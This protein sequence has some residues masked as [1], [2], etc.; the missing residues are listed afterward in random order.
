M[1][2]PYSSS[3]NLILKWSVGFS[4]NILL[5]E[6]SQRFQ[7][8]F[9]D[10]IIEIIRNL[11]N[12]NNKRVTIQAVLALKNFLVPF[13]ENNLLIESPN[14][15]S[16]YQSQILNTLKSIY[17]ISLSTKDY[18]LLLQVIKSVSKIA[19]TLQNLFEPFLTV[20]LPD[21][22]DLI[23]NQS[24]QNPK[25]KAESIKC[26]GFIISAVSESSEIYKKDANNAMSI[27]TSLRNT[28]DQDDICNI[29]IL[30]VIPYFADILKEDFKEYLDIYLPEILDKVQ[31]KVDM[32]IT[33]CEEE[34]LPPGIK[35][36]KIDTKDG[37]K[38][39]AIN[40]WTLQL[41]IKAVQILHDV[42][43]STLYRFEPYIKSTIDL[44]IPL[45]I[46][47]YNS[48]IRKTSVKAVT[49]M[50]KNSFEKEKL[51]KKILPVYI[52][53]LSKQ[54]M[55]PLD[56]KIILKGMLFTFHYYEELSKIGLDTGKEIAV[57]LSNHA[58]SLIS[59][60]TKRDQDFQNISNHDL[61]KDKITQIESEEIIDNKILRLV[62]EVIGKL[63]KAFKKDL[64][65]I[66]LIHFKD[67]YAQY[68]Y[69]E[70]AEKL[71]IL[72]AI[73]IF[74]DYVEF[75]EDLMWEL[76]KSRIVEEMIK[77]SDNKNSQIKQSALYGLG[78][79]AKV[80]DQN[81]FLIYK[82]K[83]IEKIRLALTDPN[84]RTI[85]HDIST[86]SAIGALGKIAIFHDNAY[87]EE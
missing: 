2:F 86:D 14:L 43:A 16:N 11:L 9:Q 40:N 21:F 75:C 49:L 46:Y 31:V 77:Y 61:Y 74:V 19:E 34:D 32:N 44:L 76:E 69:K 82:E 57:L 85:K 68:F 79:C 55:L 71:E 70:N 73:C 27:L 63:L 47:P 17:D 60:K 36:V 54:S 15:L 25:I 30:Q 48:D 12:S 1:I 29:A 51:I 6:F 66:F 59:R 18:E 87:I 65:S 5:K 4:I 72:S 64:Q 45:F 50:I 8:I 78:V 84:P 56:V 26:I 23:Q 53:T 35:I 3:E 37:P 7:M 42:I 58:K 67:I 13:A 52:S 81:Q 28:L 41:K 20:F 83:I 22:L 24:V 62:M 33:E 39:L 80:C 10:K 38:R